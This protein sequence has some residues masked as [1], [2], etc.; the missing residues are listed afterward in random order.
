MSQYFRMLKT[1]WNLRRTHRRWWKPSDRSHARRDP[2]PPGFGA[3]K[4]PV[5]ARNLI[6]IPRARDRVFQTLMLAEQ[7][8]D[9]Y[10]NA[11]DVEIH[12]SPS[13]RF[14]RDPAGLREARVPEHVGA[15]G[16]APD[17]EPAGVRVPTAPAIIPGTGGPPQLDADVAF[18]WTTFGLR[19]HSEVMEFE[20]G[21]KI[22][23]TATAPGVRVYHRWFFKHDGAGTLIITEE[24]EKGPLAWV[25][26]WF[27][28][29]ALHA[30]HQL[31]LDSLRAPQP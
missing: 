12:R 19:V 26:R 27:M 9:W 14:A 15:T 28:N 24:C 13:G 31:W 8:P 1:I 30:G 17:T 4:N 21:A 22:A 29:R 23:W 11:L 2:W 18:S 5:Y 7:W 10:E 25:M 16:E 6:K 3:D 20:P